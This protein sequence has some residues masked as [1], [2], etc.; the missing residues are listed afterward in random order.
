MLFRATHFRKTLSTFFFPKI[1]LCT[2]STGVFVVFSWTLFHRCPEWNRL[3]WHISYTNNC[4]LLVSWEEWNLG[5]VKT[6]TFSCSQRCPIHL[7]LENSR[8]YLGRQCNTHNSFP[9]RI[10]E[11]NRT[12]N[13]YI[14]KFNTHQRSYDPLNFRVVIFHTRTSVELLILL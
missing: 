1:S 7:K 3:A 8:V 5:N 4:N 6:G 2:F 14:H 10:K 11:R 9:C 13:K 12:M